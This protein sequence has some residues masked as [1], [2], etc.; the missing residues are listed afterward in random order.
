MARRRRGMV[1]II[2]TSDNPGGSVR[3]KISDATLLGLFTDM[4]ANKAS[5]GRLWV[6][7]LAGFS[8]ISGMLMGVIGI[9]VAG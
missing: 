2:V 5:L 3:V 4:A 6:V 9:L 7:T 8:G 1:T